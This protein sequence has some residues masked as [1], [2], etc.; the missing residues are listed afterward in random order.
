[1]YYNKIVFIAMILTFSICKLNLKFN[2][3]N[4]NI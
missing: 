2:P 1:M 4:L 3:Y